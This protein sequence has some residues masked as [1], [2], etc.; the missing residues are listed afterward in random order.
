MRCDAFEHVG[1]ACGLQ[2]SGCDQPRRGG[3]QRPRE[4]SAPSAPL[5]ACDSQRP[6]CRCCPGRRARRWQVADSG[7]E[8]VFSRDRRGCA[9]VA[10][11]VPA[12]TNSCLARR[13]RPIAP[14]MSRAGRGSGRPVWPRARA[15]R[16]TRAPAAG[17]RRRCSGA[18]RDRSERCR[19]APRRR[20]RREDGRPV[21][22]SQRIT[23]SA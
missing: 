11:R 23:P 4:C 19:G 8:R 20:A 16:C 22:V 2:C 15:S 1:S 17:R 5:L 9:I 21:N 12:S 7:P 3:C 10:S 18:P 6:D 14:A 13:A